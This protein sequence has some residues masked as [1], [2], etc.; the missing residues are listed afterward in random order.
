MIQ[1]TVYRQGRKIHPAIQQL[2]QSI[3]INLQNGGGIL[4]IQ[5]FQDHFSEYKIVV[6]GGLTCED[7]IFEGKVASEKRV[8]LLFDDVTRHFHVITNLT[9]AM[10]KQY[11]C[12]GCSKC[13]NT[14]VRS[15]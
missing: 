8:N 3:G 10:S 1:I 15:V 5:R 2:L 11:I 12:E 6:Y 4:E 14:G 13:C 7:I 9:G